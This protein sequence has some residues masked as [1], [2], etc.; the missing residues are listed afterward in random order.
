MIGRE[1]GP[2]RILEKIGQG[3]MGVVYKGI[4]TRLDQQVAI[5]VLSPEYAQDP[6]M[7][8]RFIAEAKL[9]A[10]LTHVHVVN[11]FNY[12]EDADNIFLVMEYIDGPTL[13]QRLANG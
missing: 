12:L 13:E 10:R 3:G 7:R 11:I 9:Q 8:E 5:K 4:H 2:Y 6:S 1:I